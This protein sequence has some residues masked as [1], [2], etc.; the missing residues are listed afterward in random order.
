[1]SFYD[2]DLYKTKQEYLDEMVQ[3]DLDSHQE[4]LRVRDELRSI[5][6]F[7]QVLRTFVYSKIQTKDLFNAMKDYDVTIR[8]LTSC[9]DLVDKPY[10]EC[11]KIKQHILFSYMHYKYVKGEKL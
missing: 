10:T 1:M 2:K 8:E 5:I 9:K 4:F 7:N 3:A 11:M 6:D